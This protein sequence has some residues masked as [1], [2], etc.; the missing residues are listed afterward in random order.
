MMA[1]VSELSGTLSEPAELMSMGSGR[2]A[3]GQWAGGF[4]KLAPRMTV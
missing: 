3:V 1:F 4:E 2:P